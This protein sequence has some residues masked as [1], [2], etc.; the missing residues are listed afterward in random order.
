MDAIDIDDMVYVATGARLRRLTAPDGTHWFPVVD[1]AKRLGYAGTREALRTV[2]LPEGCLAGAGELAGSAAILALGGVRASV[3]MVNLP[4]LVQLVGACRRPEAGPFRAWVAEVVAAVQRDGGYGLEPSP[5]HPGFLLPPDLV[6]VLVRLEGEFDEQAAVYAACEEYA[7][8]AELLRETREN[9]ARAADSL[10][11]L[12]VPRQRSGAAVVALTPQQLVESWAI[13]GDTRT[14]ASCLAPALVR[15][16]VRYRPQDV[17]RRTGLSGDRVRACVRILL[18]RGC[19]REV[20][21]P[22]P[23]GA[24]IYVLP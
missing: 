24:R 8:R 4:G 5:V 20:G 9:L 17:T 15:G 6:D 19:M 7:D 22:D 23:D 3:R 16:G 14:V 11:R 1:V 12:S 10:A 2:V 21:S 18:E 13:T